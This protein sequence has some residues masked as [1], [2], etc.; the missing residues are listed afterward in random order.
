[1]VQA[2]ALE[3]QTNRTDFVQAVKVNEAMR[4]HLSEKEINELTQP[5]YYLRNVGKIYARFGLIKNASKSKKS[6]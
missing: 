1:M 3:A 2:V 4:K 5:E 6:K